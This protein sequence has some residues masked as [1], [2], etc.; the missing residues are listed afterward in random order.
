MVT[1]FFSITRLNGK[2]F[3]WSDKSATSWRT[4]W[5]RTTQH[6]RCP[7]NYALTIK[8]C[9]SLHLDTILRVLSAWRYCVSIHLP[10]VQIPR[11]SLEWPNSR[12]FPS[13]QPGNCSINTLRSS[14]MPCKLAVDLPSTAER[15]AATTT[16]STRF[17]AASIP[18][19]ITTSGGGAG[20]ER[21]RKNPQ[22]LNLSSPS[23]RFPPRTN[24]LSRIRAHETT[25]TWC[26]WSS[27]CWVRVKRPDNFRRHD[28]LFPVFIATTASAF[29]HL[30][31]ICF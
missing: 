28:S 2:P 1:W 24:Q 29:L 4:T 10:T 21:R 3:E 8:P 31:F 22:A 17:D 23:L 16:A 7:L 30:Q 15:D 11:A 20:A 6:H 5:R 25:G 12:P 19:L 9:L 13:N 27:A 14:R 18:Q 26:F